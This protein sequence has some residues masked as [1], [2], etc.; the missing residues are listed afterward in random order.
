MASIPLMVFWS[1]LKFFKNL[2][3]PGLKYTWPITLYFFTCHNSYCRDAWK[4]SLWSL[5]AHFKPECCKFLFEFWIRSKYVYWD[6][7]MV[8]IVLRVRIFTGVKQCTFRWLISHD[9]AQ[10]EMVLNSSI[11][12]YLN[13]ITCISLEIIFTISLPKLINIAPF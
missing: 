9:N 2:E 12:H 11:I 5:G 10:K 8:C 13:I 1:N 7:H 3:C 6:G 4:I